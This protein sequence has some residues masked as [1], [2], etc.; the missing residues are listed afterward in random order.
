MYIN[1]ENIT[2]IVI[3]TLEKP[4]LF[5]AFTR[6][7]DKSP[8]VRQIAFIGKGIFDMPEFVEMVRFCACRNIIL[9]FGEVGPTSPQNIRALV[10]YGNVICVNIYEKDPNVSLLLN[11]KTEFEAEIPEINLI[12]SVPK[13]TPQESNA[14]LSYD[15][16]NRGHDVNDIE[17]LKLLTEPMIDYNG[18]FLG[19]WHNID[20]K[21]PINAF[22]VG[23]DSALNHRCYKRILKML[24]T[25]HIDMSCPCARCLVFDGMVW[26]G[27]TVDVYKKT[28]G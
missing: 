9:I 14:N 22:D 16:F 28:Q 4:V 26:T 10:E 7:I 6:F 11:Y 13:P 18:D 19:C 8:F 23:M 12:V 5:S 15:F 21:H 25:G 20:R 3:R 27:N 17:C 2:N 24:R 1:S